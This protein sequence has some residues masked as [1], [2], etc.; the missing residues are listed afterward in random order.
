MQLLFLSFQDGSVARAGD[1]KEPQPV[2]LVAP[3]HL[4]AASTEV[5]STVCSS[6]PGGWNPTAQSQLTF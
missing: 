2:R 1:E 5:S 6:Y 4:T 3:L